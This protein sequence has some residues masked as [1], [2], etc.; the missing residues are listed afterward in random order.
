M[1]LLYNMGDG[2]TE[3][4]WSRFRLLAP[5]DGSA[6]L[7]PVI[8]MQID[9]V[10]SSCCPLGGAKGV[11]KGTRWRQRDLVFL[12]GAQHPA[13]PCLALPAGSPPPCTPLTCV[14]F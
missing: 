4:H 2:S 3:P 13:Q 10:R 9:L 8:K 6:S 5:T 1:S 11:P 12:M 14:C 7:R